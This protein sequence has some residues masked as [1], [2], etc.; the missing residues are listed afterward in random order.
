M[1][2]SQSYNSNGLASHHFPYFPIG[3]FL[4]IYNENQH[5]GGAPSFNLH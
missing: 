3:L 1:N 2:S 5:I 4:K